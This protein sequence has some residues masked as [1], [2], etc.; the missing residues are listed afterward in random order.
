VRDPQ[1]GTCGN[2]H[3]VRADQ[4]AYARRV[5]ISYSGEI[6]HDSSLTSTEERLDHMPHVCGHWRTQRTVDIDD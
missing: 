1:D 3:V 6:Q 5:K 4:F 2:C